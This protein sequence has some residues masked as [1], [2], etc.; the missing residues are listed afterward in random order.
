[1]GK[2]LKLEYRRLFS[3]KSFYICAAVSLALILIS[4]LISRLLLN[5]LSEI[6]M[7]GV[8]G[9]EE[10][11]ATALQA[12]TSLS[13][14]K[15]I[16]SSSLTLILAIFTTIFVTEE[17][18]GDVI[19]NIYAKGY[20]RD[21]VYFAKYLSSL[22]GTLLILVADAVFS[23]VLGK[24]LFG[25]FGSAGTNYLSS[26]FAILVVIIGYHTIYFMIANTIRKT[27]GAIALSILGPIVIDLLLNL[28]S[29][30]IKKSE[31]VDLSAYWL[32]GRLSLLEAADVPSKEVWISFLVA[33]IVILA[34]GA[35]GFF[36]NRK[37]EN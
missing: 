29:T 7:E 15:G 32:P 23:I 27:G 14:L 3:A 31:D 34:F 26:L 18:T 24:T 10:I 30:L 17:Y 5:M 36:L 16:G 33:G 35:A 19:K 1:M 12:P 37:R 21:T 13:L 25:E 8:E 11:G 4:A 9:M 6:E 2:L 20:S 22:S 28:G